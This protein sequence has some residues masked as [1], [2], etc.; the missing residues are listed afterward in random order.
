M[1]L[2]RSDVDAHALRRQGWSIS[3]IARHLGRDRS[4]PT[5]SPAI[6]WARP[7]TKGSKG[8]RPAGFGKTIYRRRNN[9]SGR[10]TR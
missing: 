8:G 9:S 2:L 1:I 10:S 3:A 5:Q 4:I 7:P 6:T